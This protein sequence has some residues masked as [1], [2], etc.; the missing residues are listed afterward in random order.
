MEGGDEKVSRR[1]MTPTSPKPSQH[2]PWEGWRGAS[3]RHAWSW[4][5]AFLPG[6][7]AWEGMSPCWQ[8][9]PLGWGGAPVSSKSRLPRSRDRRPC[10]WRRPDPTSA[11]SPTLQALHGRLKDL[12]AK[13]ER[14]P[15]RLEVLRWVPDPVRP[16]PS[17]G[18]SHWWPQST[19][20][21]TQ[22]VTGDR[23]RPTSVRPTVP[24]V[25]RQ[26]LA[27]SVRSAGAQ[28]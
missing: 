21:L 19:S 3:C 26:F 22:Q 1:P 23:A 2:G 8:V 18:D 17:S 4:R 25:R 24:F 20:D 9:A 14:T 7:A 13:A 27:A 5:P 6:E 10:C 12:S 11:L 28:P 15:W 16:P